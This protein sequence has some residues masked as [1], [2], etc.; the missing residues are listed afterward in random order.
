MD[1][2]PEW[3]T[4]PGVMKNWNRYASMY[5]GEEHWSGGQIYESDT[6]PLEDG[7]PGEENNSDDEAP[8]KKRARR[9]PPV[10]NHDRH[11]YP[12]LPARD[13]EN[14][15]T[16]ERKKDLIRAFLGAHYSE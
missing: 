3:D 2:F 9:Q 4:A 5:F 8:P 13:G 1:T 11:G 10:L 14:P 12:T 16:L 7:L 15:L 6:M